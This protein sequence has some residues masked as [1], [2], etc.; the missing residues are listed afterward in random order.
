MQTL[1]RLKSAPPP[2]LTEWTVSRSI[3][4]RQLDHIVRVAGQVL[5]SH[6]GFR[7]EENLNFL[8]FILTVILPVKN[9]Q[10]MTDIGGAYIIKLCLAQSTASATLSAMT[11]LTMYSGPKKYLKDNSGI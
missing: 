10:G 4:G 6:V 11:A 5:Q 2:G 9:L 7:P 1:T 8:R 3:E